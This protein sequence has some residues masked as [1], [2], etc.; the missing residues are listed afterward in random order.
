MGLQGWPPFC[1][2]WE[3]A[4]NAT[5]LAPDPDLLSHTLRLG[6]A[7]CVFTS[8]P[9]GS[10]RS[11]RTTHGA[12]C[13]RGW[14]KEGG[15]LPPE[16]SPPRLPLLGLYGNTR[17]EFPVVT[18]FLKVRGGPILSIPSLPPVVAS[19]GLLLLWAAS[20]SA[21]GW[22]LG[23]GPS[24]QVCTRSVPKSRTRAASRQETPS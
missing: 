1:S 13:R 14:R 15:R 5:S 16:P 21:A 3:H 8:P 11:L 10:D 12:A 17:K 2:T 22:E 6:P 18:P 24:S 23:P 20:L 4:R 19:P 7:S 9:E